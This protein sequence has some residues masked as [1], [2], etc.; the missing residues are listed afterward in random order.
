VQNERTN[1]NTHAYRRDIEHYSFLVEE[2]TLLMPTVA[3]R[4]FNNV[5][6]TQT[7]S[8]MPV[9]FSISSWS[10]AEADHAACP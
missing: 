9:F 2:S 6:Y 3:R 7:G 1:A 8:P 10:V 4:I 5:K